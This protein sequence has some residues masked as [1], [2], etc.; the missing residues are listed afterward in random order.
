MFHLMIRLSFILFRDSDHRSLLL[1]RI[2][3]HNETGGSTNFCQEKKFTFEKKNICN[4]TK[5]SELICSSFYI[6]QRLIKI[7]FH[8]TSLVI[9]NSVKNYVVLF[10]SFFFFQITYFFITIIWFIITSSGVVLI[11]PYSSDSLRWSIATLEITRRV[12]ISR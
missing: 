7:T 2:K 9:L 3:F 10:S 5:I 6:L 1:Y 11:C 12:L 4:R 8:T